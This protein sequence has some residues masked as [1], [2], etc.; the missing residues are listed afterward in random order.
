[1]YYDSENGT[2]YSY[3]YDTKQYTIHSRVELPVGDYDPADDVCTLDTADKPLTMEDR[4]IEDEKPTQLDLMFEEGIINYTCN[5]G[6][7]FTCS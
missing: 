4:I 6:L 1:M 7:T 2:Y 5:L 3:D